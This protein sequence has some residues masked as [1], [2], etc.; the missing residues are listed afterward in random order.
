MEENTHIPKQEFTNPPSSLEP[1]A[2]KQDVEESLLYSKYAED[3]PKKSKWWK[4]LI[5]IIVGVLILGG[6]G[7]AGYWGYSTYIT[8]SPEKVLFKS[9]EKMKDVNAYA[10]EAVARVKV[11]VDLSDLED[12]PIGILSGML[13]GDSMEIRLTMVGAADGTDE[14]NVK[15]KMSLEL[16]AGDMFS[17]GAKTMSVNNTLYF[18]IDRIPI[19][20]SMFM[21]LSDIKD[22][23]VK[24]D[25]DKPLET[26]LDLPEFDKNKR[27]EITE[28]ITEILEEDIYKIFEVREDFGVESL[29]DVDGKVFHYE[30]GFDRVN[31][32][33][34]LNRI[35]NEVDS[36]W[37]DGFDDML[38]EMDGKFWNEV[39]KRSFD[40]WIGKKDYYL[41]K[42]E[43]KTSFE[44]PL[45]QASGSSQDA[46]RISDI[47]QIQTGLEMYFNDANSYP[48][49]PDPVVLGVGNLKSICFSA[50]SATGFLANP[51]DC[52]SNIYMRSMPSDPGGGQ[53]LYQSFDGK[54]YTIDFVI[55]SNVAGF[56]AGMLSASP[57]GLTQETAIEEKEEEDRDTSNDI[58]FM[59][60]LLM[61]DFNKPVEI[62][63]PED[64]TTA[65]EFLENMM[66]GLMGGAASALGN[67]REKSR[68]ARRT[69]DIKQ[70]QTALEMYYNDQV[71]YPAVSNPVVLGKGNFQVLCG[72]G[73]QTTSKSCDITYMAVIPSNPEPGGQDYLYNFIDNSHYIITF[74]LEEPMA[75][76]K[77]GKLEANPSGFHQPTP[78][79]EEPNIHDFFE[80]EDLFDDEI[81]SGDSDGDGL[82]NEEEIIIWGTDP[83][84]PDTD[85]DGYF[86]GDEVEKGYNPNGEGRI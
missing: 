70:I 68:D 23:W 22:K 28:K 72:S 51:N 84:N 29:D 36:E 20:F 4:T 12:D 54:S 45:D 71:K 79:G 74:A 41:K 24:Y 59:F 40:V 80:E 10:Y 49:S 82:S 69:S 14:E 21:D 42:V 50:T 85:G 65:E 39:E 52:S 19:I 78:A 11:P 25:V 73:F 37:K 8:T 38:E 17:L 13:S 44:N 61:K 33:L 60:S 34:L 5:F 64:F 48:I 46:R 86:D 62:Q 56:E 81:G 26:T 31:T 55:N 47:K 2:L 15:N 77:E 53:Y 63:E 67:A 35:K 6:I 32:E 43:F 7:Y 75:G 1:N 58:E 66:G 83:N 9:F 30:I 27:E 3:G 18:N 16:S 57:S 76:F